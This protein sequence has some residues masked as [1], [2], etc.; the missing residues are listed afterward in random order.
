GMTVVQKLVSEA[1]SAQ[2]PEVGMTSESTVTTV[3][4][5][6]KQESVTVEV[7]TVYNRNGV[8]QPAGPAR[9]QI[10]MAKVEKGQEDVQVLPGSKKAETKD[11]K[12]GQESVEVKGK[13]YDA[14]TRE[15]T[16]V[17]TMP[18]PTTS[19][20]KTWTSTDVPGGLVKM[21]QKSKMPPDADVSQTMTLVSF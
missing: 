13:K 14:V 15:F 1:K 7:T 3:L 16:M 21:E 17:V 19:Q 18:S 11:M 4:K 9:T 10:I 5:E 6:V 8:D 2:R 12:N 20:V